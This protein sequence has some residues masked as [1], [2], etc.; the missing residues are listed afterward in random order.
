MQILRAKKYGFLWTVVLVTKKRRRT[1]VASVYN[2]RLLLRT[3]DNKKQYCLC[4]ACKY[5]TPLMND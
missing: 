2:S 5:L 3:S 4:F 1:I